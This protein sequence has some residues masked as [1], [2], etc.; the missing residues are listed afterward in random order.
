M[1]DEEVDLR[2]LEQVAEYAIDGQPIDRLPAL[3][4]AYHRGDIELVRDDDDPEF[5]LVFLGGQVVAR[6]HWTRVVN[7]DPEPCSED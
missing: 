1:R 5:S 4:D 2:K 3:W 6:V 7:D